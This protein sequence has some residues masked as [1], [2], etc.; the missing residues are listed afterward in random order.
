MYQIG[1]FVEILGPWTR[2]WRPPWRRP[3]RAPMPSTRPSART[4]RAVPVPAAEPGPAG[5]HGPRRPADPEARGAGPHG[6]GF[7]AAARLRRTNCSTPSSSGS[8]RTALLLPAGPPPHAGRLLRGARPQ[9]VAELYNTLLAGRHCG[10]DRRGRSAVLGR[11]RSSWQPETGLCRR[12][13]RDRGP[14]LWEDE[15]AVAPP[16][17]G[18]AGPAEWYGQ[19]AGSGFAGRC[20]AAPP[21]WRRPRRPRR[22]W[23]SRRRPVSA[24][25]HR[26]A[27]GLRGTARH[28]AA[29]QSG[30]IHAVHAVEHPADPDGPVDPGAT[31]ARHRRAVGASLRG[32]LIHQRFRYED[33]AP[34]GGYLGPSVNIL[35][36]LDDI[37]F[38]TAR[39]AMNILSTGPIDDL[40]IVVHG[41]GAGAAAA[42]QPTVQFEANAAL[43]TAATARRST[44]T[45]L[46]GS[47]SRGHPA[48]RPGWPDLAVTTA[49]EERSLLAAGEAPGHGPAGPHHRGG[50]PAQ[51]RGTAGPDRRRRP[52][53]RTSPS[54]NWRPA[55][56][57]WPGSSAATAR[58]RA[59]PWLCGS[60]AACCCPWPSWQSSSRGAA[61][62]PLD[63][64]YPAGRV[65]GMLEDAAPRSGC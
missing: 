32:A 8:P 59:P 25:D 56:T 15:H 50:I 61:Y 20:P 45:A 24:P 30:E 12:P 23:S 51:R 1:Q 35:P 16:A 65:E 3:S 10:A 34:S 43:Y 37:T 46:S 4:T 48:R 7:G 6:R 40:S 14:R 19:L 60:T 17:A 54:L 28:G 53:R 5:R 29:R 11:F 31:V 36:V 62:L 42:T 52:R 13:R 55:R 33:L 38:G 22:R 44:W 41:L 49:A 26:R 63:P 47:W 18:L 58:A 2:C 9:R 27:R 64:D 57:S 39:G 21:R